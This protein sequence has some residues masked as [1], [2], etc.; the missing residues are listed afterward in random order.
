MSK[1]GDVRVEAIQAVI[2]V[3]EHVVGMKEDA[4][5]KTLADLY[6]AFPEQAKQL[7][8]GSKAGVSDKAS[9]QKLGILSPTMALIKREG[10]RSSNVEDLAKIVSDLG[11]PQTILPGEDSASLLPEGIA[12]IDLASLCE[13]QQHIVT[14]A[15]GYASKVSVGDRLGIELKPKKTSWGE[16]Y[17]TLR[18]RMR[19]TYEIDVFNVFDDAVSKTAS[20]LHDHVGGEVIS[21]SSNPEYVSAQVLVRHVAALSPTTLIRLMRSMGIVTQKDIRGSMEWRF[22]AFRMAHDPYAGVARNTDG[23]GCDFAHSNTRTN[24][25]QKDAESP[26]S[27]DDASK[28]QERDAII[29]MIRLLVLSRG[30][31]GGR[32][33]PQEILDELERAEHGDTSV[34]VQDLMRR[35]NDLTPESKSAD[36][37]SV[38][39]SQRQRIQGRRFSIAV[40]DGWTAIKDYEEHTFLG[41]TVRP[42]VLVQ[43]ESD[44]PGDVQ[45]QDRILYVNSMG[46]IEVDST[47]QECGIHDL[48][49]V[50]SMHARYNKK[51]NEGLLALRPTVDWDEEVDAVNTRCFVSQNR[52]NVGANGLEIYIN[53]YA[54]DHNDFI[55]VILTYDGEESLVPARELAKAIARTV[56]IDEP[57]IPKCEQVLSKALRERVNVD[58]FKT[59]VELYGKPYC[60]MRQSIF[61]SS[62]YK[63]ATTHDDYGDSDI[64]LAGARGIA[65]LD[66]RAAPALLRMLD[67]Y[68]NQIACGATPDDCK[69][70]LEALEF[71]CESV[72]P[73]EEIFDDPGASF[74][75]RSAHVFDPTDETKAARARLAQA[76]QELEA[77]SRQSGKGNQKL[78]ATE[79]RGSSPEAVRSSVAKSR[80]STKN[81]RKKHGP[82]PKEPLDQ[83]MFDQIAHAAIF[84]N[85]PVNALLT[86]G[87]FP[88]LE[89]AEVANR[90]LNELVRSGIVERCGEDGFDSTATFEEYALAQLNRQEAELEREGYYDAIVLALIDYGDFA[91]LDDLLVSVDG[92]PG[93]NEV[94]SLLLEGVEKGVLVRK[95]NWLTFACALDEEASQAWKRSA[96]ERERQRTAEKRT[97]ATERESLAK[98]K[99]ERNSARESYEARLKR[100]EANEAKRREEE[101]E[102]N[103]QL[104]LAA[105]DLV[106][107]ALGSYR[108]GNGFVSERWVQKNVQGVS[109]LERAKHLM[110]LG[111]KVGR[112]RRGTK[113]DAFI[114]ARQFTLEEWA[115]IRD[116]TNA[117]LSAQYDK[118]FEEQKA[119]RLKAIDGRIKRASVLVNTA[120]NKVEFQKRNVAQVESL[121]QELDRKLRDN[122][123]AMASLS[124]DVKRTTDELDTTG[125][126]MLSKKKELKARIEQLSARLED[127]RSQSLSHRDDKERLQERLVRA[128]KELEGFV[129]ELDNRKSELDELERERDS[130]DSEGRPKPDSREL[131][132]RMRKLLELWACSVDKSWFVQNVDGVSSTE[133]AERLLRS[134]SGKSVFVQL[135]SGLYTLKGLVGKT[136]PQ[137]AKASSKNKP[138]QLRLGSKLT[139]G[140]YGGSQKLAK[141][142]W[143]VL[144]VDKSAREALLLCDNILKSEAFSQGKRKASWSDSSLLSWLNT[145]FV[146]EAFGKDEVSLL[147]KRS[148]LRKVFVL[149]V[150]EFKTYRKRGRIKPP[151]I[152][153]YVTS[154]KKGSWWLRTPGE[155]EYRAMYVTEKNRLSTK[156]MSVGN[157]S[158]GVRPA[159]WINVDV[160][161][162]MRS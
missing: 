64:L 116:E 103:R 161:A 61:T 122:E 22:R 102:R 57:I 19:P 108:L 66:N 105:V 82:A 145:K 153:S 4:K 15:D 13:L 51:D 65:E 94:R 24:D 43:G 133:H 142:R 3:G 17:T 114:Y 84:H 149:S 46:D 63:Y 107:D 49:W 75:I 18:I 20:V 1:Y 44:D 139:I 60:A 141:L 83:D 50:L 38:S 14:V 131:V 33:F 88:E 91:K 59:M 45:S 90:Y 79:L 34:D 85:G 28:E 124:D 2:S 5:P 157:N 120:L 36:L 30:L 53:P 40:P 121:Y 6:K 128:H 93:R 39:F 80:S 23:M 112:I 32:E 9:L 35:V 104:D 96:E 155:S 95:G 16:R 70:M 26:S 140:Q 89:S 125:F 8:A 101:V 69:G 129:A 47:F 148:E 136:A 127:L 113:D 68:E 77:P 130:V 119:I 78:R 156:G 135:G 48:K 21:V 12:G 147:V 56:R 54:L 137:S 109:S 134:S 71:F 81:T 42:F 123:L 25:G 158:I 154:Q 126:F 110:T 29:S 115:P 117:L 151:E 62:Q 152:P 86:Y 41:T 97:I 11:V 52:A 98:S 55:R 87:L 58:E 7:K 37:S 74:L 92:L 76:R 118:D 150:E 146:E 27:A 31:T 72:F 67:A 143:T 73:T 138:I 106:V 10:V 99:T 159:I 144:D 132:K 100:Y 111:W 160:L 162:K